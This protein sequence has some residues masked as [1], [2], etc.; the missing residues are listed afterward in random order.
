M[1]CNKQFQIL[2]CQREKIQYVRTFE[3]NE[4]PS[5]ELPELEV[6][7]QSARRCGEE[8][9]VRDTD[10]PRRHRRERHRRVGHHA[11]H[12]WHAGPVPQRTEQGLEGLQAVSLHRLMV[13]HQRARRVVQRQPVRDDL[14]AEAWSRGGSSSLALGAKEAAVVELRVDERDVDATGVEDARELHVRRDVAVCRER[15]QHDV[16]LLRRVHIAGYETWLDF[17]EAKKQWQ[18]QRLW[19]WRRCY[20]ARCASS[21]PIYIK[22]NN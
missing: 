20:A 1:R 4:L 9:D 19:L 12:R 22:C 7:H 16:M 11:A 18:L 15:H 5:H 17:C 21:T 8:L 10:L 13:R 6:S 3:W 14:D 2:T